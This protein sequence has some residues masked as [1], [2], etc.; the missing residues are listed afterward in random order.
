MMRKHQDK[1]RLIDRLTLLFKP[2]L[3]SLFQLTN[4][5]ESNVNFISG[6]LCRL[7]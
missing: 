4:A 1:T 3:F 5:I 6:F 7:A 2:P